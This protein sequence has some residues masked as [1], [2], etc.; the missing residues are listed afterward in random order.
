MKASWFRTSGRYAVHRC[1]HALKQYRFASIHCA[2]ARSGETE[3]AI[4]HFLAG[5]EVRTKGESKRSF[6]CN[7]RLQT[8]ALPFSFILPASGKQDASRRRRRRYAV[9]AKL[10][11]K[12]ALYSSSSQIHAD[13]SSTTH[14]LAP[15]VEVDLGLASP[16]FPNRTPCLPSQQ[17][18]RGRRPRIKLRSRSTTW[19]LVVLVPGSTD[20]HVAKH[21]AISR[22]DPLVPQKNL[23]FDC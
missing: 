10:Q 9:E 14:T 6:H 12:P 13:S 11:L 19:Q 18:A 23:I 1:L 16:V 4:S 7:S 3:F 21:M 17:T 22:N 2:W 5:F 8:F 20:T 15:G